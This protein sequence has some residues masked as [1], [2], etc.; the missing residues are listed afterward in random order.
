MLIKC[1]KTEEGDEI[2]ILKQGRMMKSEEKT[3]H[4]T[5]KQKDEIKEVVKKGEA[6]LTQL[7]R[8]STSR[9]SNQ[10]GLMSRLEKK[11]KKSWDENKTRQKTEKKHLCF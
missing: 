10:F 9:S 3:W 2:F 11:K 8:A 6:K 4:R 7:T 5:K 1:K